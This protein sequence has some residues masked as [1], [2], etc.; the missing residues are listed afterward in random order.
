MEQAIIAGIAHDKSEAKVTIV[1]VPDR[2]GMAAAMALSGNR[3][4]HER[5]TVALRDLHEESEAQVERCNQRSNNRARAL[6]NYKRAL[7]IIN[8]ALATYKPSTHGP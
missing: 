8:E 6:A 5:N 7:R 4:K 3:P 1:G 2:A